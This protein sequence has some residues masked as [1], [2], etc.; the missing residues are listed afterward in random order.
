[1]LMKPVG[2]IAAAPGVGAAAGAGAGCRAST[3]TAVADNAN[4][5]ASPNVLIRS[6]V[7]RL[8]CYLPSSFG[9]ETERSSK[10][11]KAAAVAQWD[12]AGDQ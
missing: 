3:A 11:S 4:A 8:M 7:I 10:A 6:V 12:R 2:D 1:M 9:A 5:P